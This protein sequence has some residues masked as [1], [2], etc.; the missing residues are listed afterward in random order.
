[1]LAVRKS[2][3]ELGVMNLL[4]RLFKRNSEPNLLGLWRQVAPEV[5]EPI[6]AKFY[7]GGRLEYLVAEPGRVGIIKLTYRIEGSEIISNQPSAPREERTRFALIDSDV[8]VLTHG[9][10]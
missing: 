7:S 2:S 8:L 4:S 1:M 3:A 10:E 6:L 5:P 9:G